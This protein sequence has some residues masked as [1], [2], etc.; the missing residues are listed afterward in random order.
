MCVIVNELQM[1]ESLLDPYDQQVFTIYQTWRAQWMTANGSSEY[2]VFRSDQDVFDQLWEVMELPPGFVR[3]PHKKRFQRG[4]H[5][6]TYGSEVWFCGLAFPF[7]DVIEFA[8]QLTKAHYRL[9]PT[10]GLSLELRHGPFHIDLTVAWEESGIPMYSE[11][12]TVPDDSPLRRPV[13]IRSITDSEDMKHT[14]EDFSSLWDWVATKPTMP[15]VVYIP[16]DK[17]KELRPILTAGRMFAPGMNDVYMEFPPPLEIVV[18]VAN[19]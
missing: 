11:F 3:T 2:L 18:T 16:E 9:V 8:Y 17:E 1:R 13:C 7:S 15:R 6:I 14:F 19:H 10:G 4:E 5:F 12:R